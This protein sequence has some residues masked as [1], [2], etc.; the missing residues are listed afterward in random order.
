M[1][2]VCVFLHF[3]N[4]SLHLLLFFKSLLH[5]SPF[6]ENFFHSSEDIFLFEFFCQFLYR[7]Y[8]FSVV[9]YNKFSVFLVEN[10]EIQA[11]FPFFILNFLFHFKSIVLIFIFFFVLYIYTNNTHVHTYIY[12]NFPSIHK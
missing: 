10:P 9:G 8:I 7:F 1:S 4:F 12:M 3:I 6:S 11:R 5:H 2:G